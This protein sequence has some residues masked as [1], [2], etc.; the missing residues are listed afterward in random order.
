MKYNILYDYEK[1]DE[2]LEL[3]DKAIKE[4]PDHEMKLFKHKALLYKKKND[5]KEGLKIMN[6]LLEKYPDEVDLLN[7]KLYW[8]LYIQEKDE[9]IETGK[10]LTNLEPDDGNYH[11]S[12]AEALMEFGEYNEAIKEIQK[13]LELEPYGWFTYNSYLTLAKCYKEIGEYNLAR[14]ALDKGEG[15]T[16]TCF[17]G[18]E[19][20]K[21]WKD[22]K[23]K[24]LD[25]IEK[26][27]EKF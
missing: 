8:H 4:F 10:L 24:L 5:F 17:C 16:N 27:E 9:A 12:Y 13:A 25:E 14:E 6:E 20:R 21:E 2:A 19:T 3:V 1:I 15:A 7:N 11:D 22:K 23:L 26:L 18:I